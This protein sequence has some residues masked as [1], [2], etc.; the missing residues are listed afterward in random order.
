MISDTVLVILMSKNTSKDY[1]YVDKNKDIQ[2]IKNY[3]MLLNR[4]GEREL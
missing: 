4:E 3:L 2:Q 1:Y